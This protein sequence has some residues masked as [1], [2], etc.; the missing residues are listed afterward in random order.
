M[1]TLSNTPATRR[2]NGGQ[3]SPFDAL[4]SQIDRVFNDFTR[5][6][7]MPRSLWGEEGSPFPSLEMHDEGNKVML[8]AELPGVDESDIDISADG[9]MLTISGEKKSEYESKEGQ[10]GYR[11]ERTYGSFS[12][13]VSLPFD[14]D[15]DKVDARFDRGVLKLTIEKPA[16]AMR[17]TRKIP[18]KH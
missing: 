18:I 14:I 9:Q 17:A 7:G 12:R 8:A 16:E 4:Q 11:T 2:E 13:S 5:G 3:L 6:F 15:P 1:K 10:G